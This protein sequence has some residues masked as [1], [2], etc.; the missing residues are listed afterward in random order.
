MPRRARGL[1]ERGGWFYL[2]VPGRVG[3]AKRACG[4]RDVGTARRMAAI[5]Q[6]LRDERAWDL[7]EAARDGRCT[8]GDLHDAEAG[9][10]RGR[11]GLRA[12]L[13][14][15]ELGPHVAPWL[16]T[17]RADG[18]A[19]S[20]AGLY[21]QQ[22]ERWLGAH[23]RRSHLTRGTVSA[24]LTGL[25]VS[26]GTR[27]GYLYALRSFVSY[28]QAVNVLDVDPLAGYK[29]PA[30]NAA[31]TRHESEA[32]DRRLVDALPAPWRALL[33]LI[34]ATGAEVSA[35][36]AT[37]RRDLELD[38]GLV[39]VR[40]TKNALRDRPACIVEA[41]ALPILA[42]HAR[43]IVPNALLWPGLTRQQVYKAHQAAAA[44]IGLEDYTPRDARHSWAIR[45]L[46][47]GATFHDVATQLGHRD[48]SMVHRVY[49]RFLPELDGRLAR[50][51]GAAEVPAASVRSANGPM[52][53]PTP[54]HASDGSPRAESVSGATKDDRGAGLPGAPMGG[55]RLELVRG[56]G[57]ESA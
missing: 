26:P 53:G 22:V 36:L 34:H 29:A 24:W 3:R 48:T 51:R 39:H 7:L 23:P 11:D 6:R 52:V 15:V 20:T 44:A 43:G 38:R 21:A 45:A 35:A 27:R 37:K 10:L 56:P 2:W 1:I 41:W 17:L 5:V 57:D 42:E 18:G 33:A 25:A 31:R 8:L 13:A 54:T 16:A 30:P 14:D 49:A 46:G 47:R 32:N 28:L 50:D 4:T 19:E 9:G 12:R 40:G 55:T